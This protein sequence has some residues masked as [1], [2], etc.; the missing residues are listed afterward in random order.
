MIITA[1][2]LLCFALNIFNHVNILIGVLN[3]LLLFA[4]ILFYLK[5]SSQKLSSLKSPLII[6]FCAIPL[7]TNNHEIFVIL[8]TAGI[9][10]LF[11]FYLNTK[12]KTVPFLLILLYLILASFYVNGIIKFPFLFHNQ[13]ISTDDWT[14]LYISQMQH[15]ALYMPYRIR[16]LLF[17]NSVYFYVL[18]SKMSDFLTFKNF[19]D[20][21]L[22]AN[23]YP[24]VMGIILDLKSWDKPKTLMILCMLITILAAVSSR[25]VYTFDSFTLMSPFLMYFILKGFNSV[26]KISYILLFV[27]G[28]IVSRP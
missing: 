27:F 1:L 16:L 20:T 15:E 21:L 2:L 4:L 17:N 5:C 28:L 8:L 12:Y 24:L 25:T 10:P 23:L 18:L 6:F 19:Y 26:H 22:I 14:N 13:F 9:I 3:T 11:L 7:F